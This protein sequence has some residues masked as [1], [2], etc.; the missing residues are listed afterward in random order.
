LIVTFPSV[1]ALDEERSGNRIRQIAERTPRAEGTLA[2]YTRD[3][4]RGHLFQS[5]GEE[6]LVIPK[7]GVRL[8]ESLV[9]V[10]EASVPTGG[11]TADLRRGVWLRHPAQNGAG[12]FFEHAR[13]VEQVLA[14]W[15]G[16]FSYLEEDGARGVK[17]LRNPQIGAVHAIHA[18]WSVS[19]EPATVVMPTG[20]G[21]TE[22]MLSV[23]V[24]ALCRKLIVVV[25][26]D[27]L[28]TQL[29]DKFLTLGVLKEPGCRV[30]G[31]EVKCPIVGVLQHIPRSIAEVD[32]VF[33]RCQVIVTT[34]TIAGQCSG[35]VR[36]RMAHHCTHL[37]IDEAHH[38]E[39]PTWSVFKEGFRARKILQ[40]TATPFREDGRPL[41]GEIVFK[42]PL[43]KAQQE[44]YFKPIR[45]RPVVEFN[46]KRSDERIAAQAIAELKADFD[47][48]HIL[49]ARTEN[50]ARAK[51]VFK[52]YARHPEFKPVEL[53]T[54]IKSARQR[55]AARRQI[56]S[57]ESRIVVCVDMLGEGFDLPELKIAAFHDIRKTLA[58]T[59]QL[60]GRFTRSRPDLGDATFIANTADVQVQDE[61]RRLYTRDPDWNVLLPELSDRMIGE[62]LS[63]QEFLRGF[64]E[65]TKEIPLKTV[66][67][68]M[69]TVVYRTRCS[70]WT[71]E[72][73]IPQGHPR[74]HI[75]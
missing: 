24:S 25:P 41:D 17:G 62:Q 15:A 1:L 47:K 9:R 29:A 75:L 48:G 10:V 66:R 13:E 40:F 55:E 6:T 39:A 3:R 42:Y 69:S 71:P 31:T 37:F 20:T 27:A 8:P 33:C 5:D 21:K 52:L 54:G 35:D 7:R 36:D 49:M 18:H 64:T 53:H 57:G 72:N 63:L 56:L 67:P 2:P 26:T 68:A 50:V 73:F 45:F 51:E 19:A 60:A 34:S 59:L 14:S 70:A 44:G 11:D 4:I 43:K 58:V 65:F 30:L 61:L 22:T 46:P 12:R 74:H 23:L 32:E 38:A 16:A 28:R